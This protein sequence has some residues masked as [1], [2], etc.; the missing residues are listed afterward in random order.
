M[1]TFPAFLFLTLAALI[2]SSCGAIP[3]LPPLDS[4]VTIRTPQFTLVPRL[5]T[6]TSEAPEE[7]QIVVLDYPH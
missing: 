4:T 2:L 3:T 5:V 1:K 7:T 6:V